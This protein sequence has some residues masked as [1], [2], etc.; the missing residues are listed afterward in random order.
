MRRGK[1]AQRL[2][3]K[4]PT[5]QKTTIPEEYYNLTR[6]KYIIKC[7]YGNVSKKKTIYMATS[8]IV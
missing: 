3:Q 2:C 1:C 8:F 4:G 6:H 5:G 7:S